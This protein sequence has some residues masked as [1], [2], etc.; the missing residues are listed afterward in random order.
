MCEI[1]T[2]FGLESN[3]QHE[4]PIDISIFDS[5]M[6]SRTEKTWKDTIRFKPKLRTYMLHTKLIIKPKRGECIMRYYLSLD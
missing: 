3:F 6:V 5:L 1:C 2:K 4:L